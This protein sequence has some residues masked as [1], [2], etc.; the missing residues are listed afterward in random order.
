MKKSQSK[1]LI[2]CEY[3]FLF[4]AELNFKHMWTMLQWRQDVVHL[5]SQ[6][7]WKTKIVYVWINKEKRKDKISNESFHQD[8][9]QEDVVTELKFHKNK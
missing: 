3:L 1:I 8:D 9:A 7:E 6:D 5:I 2:G 4:Y